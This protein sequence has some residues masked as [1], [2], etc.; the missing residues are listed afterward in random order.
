MPRE[1]EVPG[2]LGPIGPLGPLGAL[3]F[4]RLRLG[5]ISCK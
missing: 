1:E 2:L 3:R 5:F 4:R